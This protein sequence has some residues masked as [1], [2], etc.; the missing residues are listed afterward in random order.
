MI[1]HPRPS[2]VCIS[3]YD[4]CLG[5]FPDVRKADNKA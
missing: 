1:V 4:G 3:L 5:I 2:F